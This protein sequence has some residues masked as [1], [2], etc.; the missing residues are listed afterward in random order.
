MHTA[1]NRCRAT[2]STPL[3]SHT[4]SRPLLQ[5]HCYCAAAEQYGSF[6]GPNRVK[7]G[8]DEYTADHILIAVGGSPSFPDL[9]GVE[10][11]ISSDGF[12]A[13]K[14]QPKKVSLQLRIVSL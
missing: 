9:P 6:V 11:C 14:T 12:F 8:E 1:L 13:L 2:R 4:S 10:H 5:L 3:H 7:V